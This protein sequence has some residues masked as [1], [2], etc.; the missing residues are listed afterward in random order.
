MDVQ[1][2]IRRVLERNRLA[3]LATQRDGQPHAS[4][5]A[6]TPSGGLGS[7]VFATYRHTLKY[8]SLKKDGRVAILIEDSESSS[9]NPDRRLVITALGEVAQTPEED[10]Q[11][12]IAKHLA[13]HPDL[14]EFL[15]S[16]DCE[17]VRIGIK[18]YQVVNG[19]EDVEWYGIGE[20]AAT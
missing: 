3:V 13:R 15:G 11:A 2:T 7:I 18:A 5:M 9:T 14:T 1:D 19:I 16:T 10:K 17:L 4:L 12:L 6:Y 20:I 8:E